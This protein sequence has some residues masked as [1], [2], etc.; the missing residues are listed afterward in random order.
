[1]HAPLPAPARN[2]SRA[3]LALAVVGLAITSLGS[4]VFSLA[5]FTSQATVGS[6]TFTAGTVVIGTNPTS[7][8]LTL[9]P[10]MPGD[11]VTAP[12]TVSNTGTAQ[13]RY[14]I[15][16]ATTNP[17]TK[18]LRSQLTITVKSG[19]T[20]CTNAGFAADGT[21]VRSSIALGATT[22]VAG[23]P[24]A[25]SQSGDRTLNAGSNEVLCFQ[26]S[27]PSATGNAFQGA[28]ATTTFT[29]DAEQTANNP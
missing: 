4:A 20:T 27:L 9:N 8:L 1:M 19:V 22:A 15:S 29:F 26:V 14:A 11:S 2:R 24:S 23:D 7:A 13:L 10:M 5:Y 18:D 16:A 12:L 17:D 28:T 3:L 6:N 25:G 21:S